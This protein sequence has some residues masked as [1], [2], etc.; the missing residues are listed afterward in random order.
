[1]TL[2]L[3]L[4]H[5]TDLALAMGQVWRTHPSEDVILSIKSVEEKRTN[6]I[7]RT[8]STHCRLYEEL[9][10]FE[11]FLWHL[12]TLDFYDIQSVSIMLARGGCMT[13]SAVLE[14]R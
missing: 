5:T 6:A 1:M 8:A 3:E 12:S 13:Y 4:D 10:D 7:L 2:Q 14:G 9:S 11:G